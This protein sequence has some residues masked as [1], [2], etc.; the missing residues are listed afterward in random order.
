[1]FTAGDVVADPDPAQVRSAQ[2]AATKKKDVHAPKGN[3]HANPHGD[4][5]GALKAREGDTPAET[6]TAS[7]ILIRYAGA[8]RSSPDVT[9]SKQEAQKLAN[10]VARKAQK[11]DADFVQ[12]ANEYT[13]DPSGKGRGGSLGTF[14]RGRM[15]PEFDKAT[16]ELPAGGVSEVV[17]TAFGFHII[18][19]DK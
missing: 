7:H 9:R 14:P 12:L 19:R 4:P 10:E 2:V 5:H 6:A 16:F 17:E 11:P 8:M 13:E 1:M 15:V 18:H 3:P